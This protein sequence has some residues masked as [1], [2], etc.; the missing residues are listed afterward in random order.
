MQTHCNPK[1][2]ELKGFFPALSLFSDDRNLALICGGKDSPK[3]VE[4]PEFTTCL[5]V[6]SKK[7]KGSVPLNRTVVLKNSTMFWAA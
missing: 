4:I 3:N 7:P 5:S 2:I 6:G 1:Q